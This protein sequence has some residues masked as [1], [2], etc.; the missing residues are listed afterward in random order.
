[1]ASLVPV[2]CAGSAPFANRTTAPRPRANGRLIE[3][4]RRRRRALC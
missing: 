3:L 2:L 4:A 1:M